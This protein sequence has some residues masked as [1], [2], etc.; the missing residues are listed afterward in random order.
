MNV[1]DRLRWL[2][3]T[4]FGLGLAPVVP[5][6]FGTLAGVVPAAV[7][8]AFL[9]GPALAASLWG[10]A[11]LGFVYGILQTGF[12]E[13]VFQGE[14]PRAFVLDE[15]V[16][17]L[18]TIAVFSTLSGHPTPLVQAAGFVAFRVFDI[19]KVPPANRLEELHGA[20]GI[21]A[22]DVAAGV[23]AGAVLVLARALDF[24]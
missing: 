18:V 7:L 22:D 10:L 16:G 21:M 5:G 4:G 1:A 12:S 11:A 3:L 17:Y 19:L 24:V 15:V 8:S 14:D 6:T 23:W 20:P 9:T 2:I 13:R